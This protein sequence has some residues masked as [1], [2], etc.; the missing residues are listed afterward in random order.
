MNILIVVAHLDDET[1]GMY[2]TIQKLSKNNNVIIYSL[3]RGRNEINAEARLKVISELYEKVLVD[4]Y[5]DL[6]L[7]DIY[8]KD[9]ANSIRSI[10]LGNN[11]NSVYTTAMDLHNEHQI[12]NQCTK[13][14]IRNT[15]V[16]ELYEMY[17]PVSSDIK[18]F[19]SERVVEIDLDE[20]IKACKKYE[21]EINKKAIN[22]IKTAHRFIGSKYN[23]K[24]AEL[25]NVVFSIG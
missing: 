22:K 8:Q 14:A 21:T 18:Q 9:I 16:K 25:F 3:C 24:A 13:V 19:T 12:V 23:L 2:G 5:Y 1:F 10:I 17:I 7:S 4:E 15:S 20:K 11:I 6:H